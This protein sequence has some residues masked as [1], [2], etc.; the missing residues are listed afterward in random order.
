M[1]RSEPYWSAP[2]TLDRAAY[3]STWPGR[4][5]QALAEIERASALDPLSRIIGTDYGRILHV[6]RHYDAAI[7]QLQHTLD[8]LPT[9]P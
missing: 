8:L 5:T 4:L 1:I 6:G 2:Q 7:R 9:L 3:L